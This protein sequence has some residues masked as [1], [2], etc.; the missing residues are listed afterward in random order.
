MRKVLAALAFVLICY[1]AAA[2]ASVTR[3]QLRAA[4]FNAQQMLGLVADQQ[5]AS[6]C[7]SD[8]A[9][10]QRRLQEGTATDHDYRCNKLVEM[11]AAIGALWSG[12]TC[13]GCDALIAWCIA[14]EIVEAAKTAF[15]A[16]EAERTK[17]DDSASESV[18]NQEIWNNM[19]ARQQLAV[20]IGVIYWHL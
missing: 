6:H 5:E 3:A 13:T 1:P 2:E 4:N 17:A 8:Y 7:D 15:T 9:E 10:I 14:A 19:T 18:T 20:T 11:G 12:G 16:W